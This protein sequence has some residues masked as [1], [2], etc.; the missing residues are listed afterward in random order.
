VPCAPSAWTAVASSLPDHRVLN[1]ASWAPLALS[2]RRLALLIATFLA[3][4]APLELLVD[5]MLE[6]RRGP[7][8]AW[9]SRIRDPLRAGPGH[10]VAT[11]AQRWLTVV[12]RVPAPWSRRPWALPVLT[13]PAPAPATSAKL[14]KRHRTLV[15]LAA[16]AIRRDRRRP[17]ARPRTGPPHRPQA[18]SRRSLSTARAARSIR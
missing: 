13:R 3:P 9:K 6:R 12:L 8:I 2:R 17:P 7:K 5:E 15:D 18:A 16:R 4:D 11:P 14:G 1:R 10:P